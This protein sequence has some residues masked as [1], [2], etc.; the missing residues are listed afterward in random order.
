MRITKQAAA[1]LLALALALS[2]CPAA[3]AAWVEP[4]EDVSDT[5]WYA[6]AV[7][8][9]YENVLMSG[10]SST[11]FSPGV[12]TTRGMIVTI[13]HR[14]EGE[15]A[16]D[17]TAF[18]S[19]VSSGAWYRDA[20]LWAAENGVV[21][22][23]GGGRFGPGDPITRE[24]LTVILARYADQEGYD[25]SDWADLSAFSDA[26]SVSSWAEDAMAWA[27]GAGLIS[28]T[29]GGKLSP[30]GNATR[31][32]VAAILMRFCENMDWEDGPVT[33]EIEARELDEEHIASGTLTEDGISYRG[34]YVDN[35]VIVVTEDGWDQEDVNDLVSSYDGH[36]VGQ[37]APIC[38]FQVGFDESKPLDELN[39]IVSDLQGEYGVED[40]Y[41]NTVNE[42]RG[43]MT[44]FYPIDPWGDIDSWSEFF[45]DGGNWGYE[46]IN[47][48]T[49][50]QMVIDHCGEEG[51][52]P[53]VDFCVIDTMFDMDESGHED[54]HLNA[55]CYL[56]DDG[57][58]ARAMASAA[59][60][61]EAYKNAV[62]GIHVAGI[63]G[64]N[65][66][67]SKGLT[68]VNIHSNINGYALYAEDGTS[69][70]A[71]V[72]V[73][74]SLFRREAIIAGALETFGTSNGKPL[75]INYSQGSLGKEDNRKAA[76]KIGK[77]LNK[78]LKWKKRDFLIVCS[79]GN[80]TEGNSEPIAQ[81]NSEFTALK[82]SDYPDVY[83]R[84]LVVGGAKQSN[85]GF[86]FCQDMSYGDR[87]DVVAPAEGIYSAA[88]PNGTFND[89]DYLLES[90]TS[91][92]APFVAGTAGL[93][94]AANDDLS[95]AQ[96]KKML[97]DTAN[98]RLIDK[99]PAGR[100]HTMVNAAYAVATALGKTYSV[101]SDTPI[102]WSLRTD[103]TLIIEDSGDLAQKADGLY[104]W[105][106]WAA[107]IETVQWAG[108][109][110]AV[111]S[112][113]FQYYLSLKT[114][115]FPETVT[116]I[117]GN[118]IYDCPELVSLTILNKDADIQSNAIEGVNKNFV[119]Y[120][121]KNSTAQEYAEE[122]GLAFQALDE[123]TSEDDW[124]KYMAKYVKD[125]ETGAAIAGAK[126]TVTV[127][128]TGATAEALTDKTGVATILMP[129]VH[130][131]YYTITTSAEGYED[132]TEQY[133]YYGST[134]NPT[135]PY[136][137][138]NSADATV[139]LHPKHDQP[140]QPDAGNLAVTVKDAETGAPISGAEVSIQI[141][142]EYTQMVRGIT[143]DDGRAWVVMPDMTDSRGKG[144]YT[145]DKPD[146]FFSVSADGYDRLWQEADGGYTFSQRVYVEATNS[147]TYTWTYAG[148]SQRTF[149]L[150][151]AT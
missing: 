88:F 114:L 10:V 68:G 25:L 32:Q 79:A 115:Y 50:R 56:G 100:D 4:F 110:T 113:M 99:D 148:A 60:N 123:E 139:R 129:A 124:F 97:C 135:E 1:L 31:A 96:L 138:Y 87:I 104:E 45:P 94:L 137:E 38:V 14:M 54:V 93:M 53:Y 19:D 49:A 86:A 29:G 112:G 74:V 59:E 48:P 66:N 57:V 130:D 26:G 7:A 34:E 109:V 41:L 28:G 23:Y 91:M 134:P 117:D 120:G 81:N 47:A 11:R 98:I 103:G 76:K 102:R 63:L 55:V 140:A 95:G 40:A 9:A 52:V 33:A 75:I 62:H 82:R 101:E 70:R 125:A 127:S 108:N 122:N 128:A 18:F 131:S 119:L 37:I 105:T 65:N 144:A 3:R 142:G 22:G 73:K 43:D 136:W 61:K 5:A 27:C 64:A 89:S 44:L 67:N 90:G 6:D 77:D 132:Y 21:A 39:E 69:R 51:K 78:F 71:S 35:E 80:G 20:V 12:T 13:L 111:G 46:A 58:R 106:R 85:E 17:G 2:L 36:V 8:Y 150:A 151:P 141:T 42:I 149:Q 84:I 83:D 15:P 30:K 118:T 107:N 126:V 16:P 143:D 121:Y 24:Q 146:V 72:E 92:A 145:P 133:Y 116:R 147:W